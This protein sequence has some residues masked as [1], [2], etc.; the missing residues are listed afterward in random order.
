MKKFDLY[1]FFMFASLLTAMGVAGCSDSP[2]VAGTAEEPNEL[3]IEYSS[4]SQ[5][6][7][8]DYSSSM[9][10]SSPSMS[11]SS[12]DA[13]SSSIALSSSSSA[14]SSSSGV[15]SSSSK[16]GQGD[17]DHNPLD[18]NSLEYVLYKFK[19]DGYEFDDNVLS[20]RTIMEKGA[21]SSAPMAT[22]FDGPGLH[23]LMKRV[24]VEE[25][26][27]AAAVEQAS[28]IDSVLNGDMGDSC[29]LYMA[30]VWDTS[31]RPAAYILA[32]ISKDTL[33]VIDVMV[34]GCEMSLASGAPR[35]LVYYCGQINRRPVEVH[36]PV[37][38][39]LDGYKCENNYD[40]EKIKKL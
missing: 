5:D 10:L 36:I 19:I 17:Y 39:K 7:G 26:F 21:A 9:V 22:E 8:D 3:A 34:D 16:P 35:F 24:V 38:R 4:S 27:P 11:S 12:V 30:N 28:L 18:P 2:S 23:P 15:F 14:P 33:T 20:S 37:D 31:N 13:S 29:M 40:D 25:Y 32:G 6:G 1:L